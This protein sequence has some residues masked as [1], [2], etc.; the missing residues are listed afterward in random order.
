ML[1]TTLEFLADELKSYVQLKDGAVFRNEINVVPSSLMK[2]DGTFAVRASQNDVT[3]KI[4]V[5]LVNIEEDRVAESQQYFQRV[6]DKIRFHNPPVNVNL[7]VLFSAMADNYLSEL[8]LLSYV[9]GFFQGS[10]VF[11]SEKYPHLNGRVEDDKP[12]QKVDKLLVNLHPLTLEQQNNL[13]AAIGAKYMPSV[14]YKV[15]TVT[16]AD[17]EPKLEAPPIKEIFIQNR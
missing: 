7:Y 1:R 14:L 12:W 16:F 8:R 11:D 2:P 5:T 9:I 10:P 17:T 6:A 15:R 13:W 3:F 4:I